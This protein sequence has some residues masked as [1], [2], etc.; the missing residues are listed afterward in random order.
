MPEAGASRAYREGNGFTVEVGH[1]EVSSVKLRL[2]DEEV[3]LSADEAL[4][5]AAALVALAS[6]IGSR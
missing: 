3:G 5:L 1:G 4:W 6:P 2:N